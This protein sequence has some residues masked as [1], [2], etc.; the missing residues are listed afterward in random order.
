MS[1]E[2]CFFDGDQRLIVCNRQYLEIYDLVPEVV[3]PGITLNEIVH[4]RY[5]VGSA[6]KMSQQDNLAWRNSAAVIRHESDTTI[7]LANWRTDAW[8]GFA[9]GR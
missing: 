7:E 5:S 1:Q 6:P 9:T 3:R 8:C 4:L 2:H